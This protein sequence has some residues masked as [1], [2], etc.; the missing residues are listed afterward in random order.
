[1]NRFKSLTWFFVEIVGKVDR[2]TLPKENNPKF[3]KLEIYN[4]F[5]FLIQFSFCFKL[6]YQRPVGTG[7]FDINL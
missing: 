1:M 7:G 6:I 5:N 4:K 2:Y 3:I